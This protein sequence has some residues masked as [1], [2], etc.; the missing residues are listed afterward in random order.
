MKSVAMKKVLFL[1]LMVFFTHFFPVQAWAEISL[2]TKAA[3]L[4]QNLLNSGYQVLGDLNYENYVEL[5]F[6]KLYCQG[7][8]D[9]CNGNNVTNR[10]LTAAVP[11]LPGQAPTLL[12]VIFRLRRNEAVVL[13]G[14]TPPPCDYFSYATFLFSRYEEGWGPADSHKIFSSFGDPINRFTIKTFGGEFNS[15]IVLIFTA[16]RKTNESI[17]AAA[18]RAGFLGRVNTSVIPSSLLKTNDALDETTD[19]IIIGQRTAL[20]KD[21]TS[22]GGGYLENPGVV[23]FRVTPPNDSH[24]PFPTPPQVVRGTG[25]TE[26]DLAPAVDGLRRAIL[27]TYPGQSA[28]EL[29]TDQWIKQSPVALQTLTNTLGDSSDAAYLMTQEFFK[30]SED[31]DDFLVIYGVNHQ[32]SGKATYHNFS[33][34]QAYKYCGIATGFDH[35]YSP[36]CFSF[37]GSA[38]SYLPYGPPGEVDKLYA[39]KVARHCDGEPYCMEVPIA[40]CGEGT[41][42]DDQMF[43]AFRAYVEPGTKTGPSYTELL[44][45]RV[46]H[47]TAPKP[48]L[49]L[50][51]KTIE[52]DYPGP[53]EVSFWVSSGAPVRWEAEIE[54]PDDVSGATIEPNQGVISTV[55]EKVSFYVTGAHPGSYHIKITVKDGQSRFAANEVIVVLNQP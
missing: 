46:I 17:R 13:I 50:L 1:F 33:I 23:V 25:Q 14:P 41:Q 15:N 39:I 48:S 5:N 32:K 40:G 35:C 49:E 30:L 38:S 53:A 7:L 26:F 42:I 29:T 55:D 37:A 9:S 52:S 44:F 19:Q 45:D 36:D 12:P 43:V 2:L 22:D 20:W 3:V 18:I 16:D 51:S 31:P 21:G 34:Y 24:D 11:P 47:F 10:Y 4:K 54:Y 8:I 6:M 27:D 28:Q